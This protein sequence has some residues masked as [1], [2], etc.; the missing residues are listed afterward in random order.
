MLSVSLLLIA[1]HHPELVS[2]EDATNDAQIAIEQMETIFDHDGLSNENTASYQGLY[3][4][5]LKDLC[6]LAGVS[7]RHAH[8]AQSFRQ[9]YELASMAYQRLLL[10]DGHVPPLGD[11]GMGMEPRLTPAHGKF[12]S[13]P[14]GLYI[15]NTS[16]SYISVVCGARSSVHKQMDDTS[17][18]MWTAGR[19]LVLDAGVQNYDAANIQAA[20]IRTQPGHSGLFFPKFDD[21]PLKFFNSGGDNGGRRVD[22]SMTINQDGPEDH[23]LCEYTLNQHRALREIHTASPNAATITD[24]AWSPDGA[25]AVAR[26]LLDGSLRLTSAIGQLE[27]SDGAVWVRLSF[28]A[29]TKCE[30]TSGLISWSLSERRQCWVI[31][32]PVPAG[33]RR[34]KIMIETGSEASPNAAPA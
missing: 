26:F 18:M 11:G 7:S 3:V 22:A 23:I 29:S 14:N 33:G 5:L 15:H 24:Q 16:D 28:S 17:I 27:G 9:R 2:D 13:P 21:Q 10:P 32:I 19:L 12:L 25:P 8:A 1:V 6:E 34:N 31:E 30:I 20:R 4:R